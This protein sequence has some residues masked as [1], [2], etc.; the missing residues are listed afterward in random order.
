MVAHLTAA[1]YQG[2]AA[3]LPDDGLLFGAQCR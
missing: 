1:K 3:G 2:I